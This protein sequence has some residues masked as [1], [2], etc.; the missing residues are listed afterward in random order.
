MSGL[1][2]LFHNKPGSA[3]IVPKSRAL[4]LIILVVFCGLLG[5]VGATQGYTSQGTC[6]TQ[7]HT[8]M[9]GPFQIWGSP[10]EVCANAGE[11]IEVCWNI[12]PMTEAPIDVTSVDLILFDSYNYTVRQQAMTTWL[13]KGY[14]YWTAR[15]KYRIVGDEAYYRLKVNYREWD[16]GHTEYSGVFPIVVGQQCS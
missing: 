6:A 7:M 14:L 10:A 5:L 1:R 2:S 3:G 8:W 9:P 12:S 4:A 15:T 13:N 11:R 16:L